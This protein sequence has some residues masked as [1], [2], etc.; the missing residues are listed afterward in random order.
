MIEG[1]VVNFVMKELS[2]IIGITMGLLIAIIGTLISI[3]QIN[4]EIK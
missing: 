2:M 4:G 3:K 1:N